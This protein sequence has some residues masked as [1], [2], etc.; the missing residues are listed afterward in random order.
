MQHDVGGSFFMALPVARNADYP[1]LAGR[2]RVDSRASLAMNSLRL[3]A[4]SDY[5]KV[6]SSRS[7]VG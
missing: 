7:I 4:L 1:T 6:F 5:G 3:E 2:E